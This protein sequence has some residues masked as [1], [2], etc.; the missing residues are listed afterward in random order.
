M[1]RIGCKIFSIADLA[2]LGLSGEVDAPPPCSE[3]EWL[4]GDETEEGN[5]GG[6]KKEK[7]KGLGNL[8]YGF[9]L[10]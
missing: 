8:E 3:V 2:V 1:E 6:R 10:A 5:E 9:L 4:E 7:K